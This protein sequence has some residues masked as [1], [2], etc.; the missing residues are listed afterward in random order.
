MGKKSLELRY[1]IN[2]E[3]E[4]SMNFEYGFELENYILSYISKSYWL[5]NFAFWVT[6]ISLKI[7]GFLFPNKLRQEITIFSWKILRRYPGFSSL[8]TLLRTLILLRFCENLQKTR[9]S[10]EKDNY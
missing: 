5:V 7:I 9:K 2:V 8:S 6:I 10:I 1:I 3:V 4:N